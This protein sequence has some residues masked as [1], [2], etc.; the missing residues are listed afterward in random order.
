MK[1]FIV[2]G[3]FAGINAAKE[4]SKKLS[5]SHEIYLINKQGY[6][7]LLP[8]LPDIVSNRLNENDITENIS[9]LIPSSVKFL[10]EE[11]TSVEFDNKKIY[12]K[13]N[14]YNYDYLVMALGSK[15]NFFNFNQ[16]LDKVNV[17]DSL[18]SAEKIRKNFLNHIKE[19]EE[20]S[21]VI[22]GAGFTGIELACNLYD[23]C[24][25]ESKKINIT[26]VDLG[27]NLLPMVSDKSRAHVLRKFEKLEFNIC[28]ENEIKIFDGKNITLKNEEVIKDAFF[29]WCSGVK[30]SLKPIGSYD[31][32]PDGR[33]LVD[34]F[35]SI[36]KYPQVY[37]AGD[38]AAIKDEKNNTILRRAVNFAE[39][40]GK[41][42]GRNVAH[43]IEGK[44]IKIFKP[45]DLGWI[46]PMYIT[47]VGVALG[48]E[49][50]GRKGIFMHYIICGI[51]N[52]SFRN[53]CR[54]FTAAIKYTF[55]RLK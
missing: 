47:S 30:T 10:R 5:S 32:L 1:I 7:T 14:E 49:V 21:L 35:L 19:R 11:I 13:D 51:K 45:I 52:Y 29:C 33:I 22:S 28:L 40:S 25:K 36:S 17:L 23:L 24:K 20:I 15:T 54:E 55:I 44:E 48:K 16:N 43:H 27:K 3:G 53:F 8:N 46:I 2:G 50:R 31:T 12:T 38:S 37:I 26:M 41:T 42:A 6:T 9:N 39:M 4:L 34:K 18:S